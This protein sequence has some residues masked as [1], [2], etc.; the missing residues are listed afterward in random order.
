MIETP[1]YQRK[2]HILLAAVGDVVAAVYTHPIAFWYW[3]KAIDDLVKC[4]ESLDIAGGR[5]SND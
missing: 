1:E 5:Y 3:Q 2:Y 4:Y